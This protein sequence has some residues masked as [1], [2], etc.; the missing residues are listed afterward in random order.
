VRWVAV[1]VGR[2]LDMLA[3][4]DTARKLA[5]GHTEKEVVGHIQADR[6]DM[7]AAGTV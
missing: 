7:A 3:L 5:V 6:W 1:E 2:E 4:E